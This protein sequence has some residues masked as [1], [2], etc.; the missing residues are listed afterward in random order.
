M[1]VELHRGHPA[2]R[3][4]VDRHAELFRHLTGVRPLEVFADRAAQA[5]PELLQPAI[6][7]L[8]I[9]LAEFWA[10]C[11]V[12]PDAV[13]GHSLGEYAAACVAGV[14][15][16]DEGLEL[17][18]ERGRAF[19]AVPG[20]GRMVAVGCTDVAELDGLVEAQGGSAAVAAYNAPRRVTVSGS[21]TEISELETAFRQRGWATIAL[22]TTHAFHSP[23]VAAAVP[24]VVA[25]AGRITHRRPAVPMAL[26]VTGAWAVGDELG[27][28]YW[29]RQLT[30]PVRFSDGVGRLLDTGCSVFLEVGPGRTLT[31]SGRARSADYADVVWLSGLSARTPDLATVLAHL[32]CMTGAGISVDWAGYQAPLRASRAPVPAG[33]SPQEAERLLVRLDSMT[34]DQ[35]RALLSRLAGQNA[36]GPTQERCS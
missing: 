7:L 35:M 29:G 3:T 13:L 6:F 15:R 2:F 34:A 16:P 31:T 30:S 24:A 27:A 12:R 17:V 5:R 4:A 10:S 21:D 14:V 19:A 8:Q 11:G 1:A 9:A 36:A 32:D 28:Q 22:D 18:S 25:A 26:N 33:F 20:S 23:L